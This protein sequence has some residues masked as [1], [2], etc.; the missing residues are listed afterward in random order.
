MA[1]KRPSPSSAFKKAID[2]T[3]DLKNILNHGSNISVIPLNLI[4][5]PITH[6]RNFYDDIEISD[7][8]KSIKKSGLLQ[9]IVV[10]KVGDRFER[11]IG[12]K[13]L[14]A[15][16]LNNEL[17]IKA[18]VLENIDDETAALI[19]ISENLFRQDPNI[20]DQM[21]AIFDYIVVATNL[22]HNK[23][24]NLL[25]KVKSKTELLEDESEAVE[26][27]SQILE[28]NLSIGIRTFMDK[29]RVLDINSI[30]VKA[31]QEKKIPYNIA[32]E[33][34]KLKNENEIESFL[35]DTIDNSLSLKELKQLITKSQDK[36]TKKVIND[37][38]ML[39]SKKYQKSLAKLD[40]DKQKLVNDYLNKIA[41]LME[42]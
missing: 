34:N 33:L 22:E 31:I 38:N 29:L 1:K 15:T 26:Q 5:S 4:S 20:Y 27:I 17:E 19:T 3:K 23:I 16:K 41:K 40:D 32:I 24:K 7:L 8:A 39:L 6:D 10:R 36:D 18:I 42:K 14:M 25:Y 35:K 21:S 9:P 13:R 2:T 30:L 28:S 11:L 12:F 37:K